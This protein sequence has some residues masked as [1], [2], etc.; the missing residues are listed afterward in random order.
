MHK[1]VSLTLLVHGISR[2]HMIQLSLI[3][4]IEHKRED[5]RVE[6]EGQLQIQRY[7][8]S[9]ECRVMSFKGLR[10][11]ESFLEVNPNLVILANSSDSL[12]RLSPSSV[13]SIYCC[14]LF[15]NLDQGKAPYLSTMPTFGFEFFRPF[16]FN[17]VST[18]SMRR[19][20]ENRY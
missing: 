20:S 15:H 6:R 3:Q 7:L 2:G 17:R 12:E 11:V 10:T 9:G 14:V 4:L 19:E 5:M 16:R 13:L 18:P 8:A 1:H